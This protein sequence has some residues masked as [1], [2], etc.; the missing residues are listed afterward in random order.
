MLLNMRATWSFLA[1]RSSL[2]GT[3]VM[4]P[5]VRRFRTSN[6]ILVGKYLELHAAVKFAAFRF[7]VI[8]GQR[9][10]FAITL[11]LHTACIDAFFGQ[12]IF[13]RFGTALRQV[14]VVRLAAYS[15]G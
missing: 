15:I 5:K 9:L 7:V 8:A 10:G 3:T 13:N 6:E 11:G 12:V 4:P 14:G 2:Y 1:E